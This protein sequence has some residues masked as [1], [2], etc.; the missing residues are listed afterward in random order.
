MSARGSAERGGRRRLRQVAGLAALALL[1][2]ACASTEP[3]VAG[4]RYRP[5]H[6]SYKVGAP[7]QING[8]WYYPKV[9][10]SYD[11]TG[12]A[13]WYGEAFDK[14]LTANGEIFDLNELTAAH[15][16][17][18]LPSIVEVTNLQNGRR[19]QLRVNDRGPY[20]Q[21]RIIDVSRRAAQLLGFE[22]SGTTNVDVRI[23][24]DE[25]IR[26]A[27][28]A[29][30]GSTGDVVLAAAAVPA[31]TAVPAPPRPAPVP[32]RSIAVAEL[33]PPSPVPVRQPP[34]QSAE[35]E[36][37]PELAAEPPAHRPW[38]IAAAH[39]ETLPPRLGQPR[40]LPAAEPD[41][42][43]PPSGSSRIFIQ[44]GAFAV[45]ENAQRARSR[46]SA[47]ANVEVTNI[48]A[49]GS[50]LYRVRLGPVATAEEA[51]RLLSRL[52]SSGFPDARIVKE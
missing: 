18:P 37:R 36:A 9:D 24:K 51:D 17:L 50:P 1:L 23:L 32:E 13:S 19:L 12:V 28:A 4:G 49:H 46:F 27:E 25:S 21:N 42:I 48:A 22:R 5:G 20:A 35:A 38:L 41:R 8:V 7:Y 44:A 39:A 52:V 10:Y 45:P 14:Q 11:E 3:R 34:P 26:V 47:L 2:T 31:G 29:K 15:R 40:E 30:R 43:I 16:T 6:P 33:P